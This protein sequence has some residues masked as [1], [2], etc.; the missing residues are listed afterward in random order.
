MSKD[1]TYSGIGIS[2]KGLISRQEILD[3]MEAIIALAGNLVGTPNGYAYFYDPEEKNLEVQVSLGCFEIV[4][5]QIGPGEGLAGRVWK[6]GQPLVVNNY[7][8]WPG[9]IRDN[10]FDRLCGAV[11]VPFKPKFGVGGVMG[12]GYAKEGKGFCQRDIAILNQFSLLASIALDNAYLHAKL[13]QELKE[14][15][16]LEDALTQ[17][18]RELEVKATDL[19]ELNT[20][21]GVLLRRRD[22]DKIELEKKVLF[23]I[24]QLVQPCI[25]ELEK[26]GLDGRQ[27]AYIKIL[28]SNLDD[29]VSRFLPIVSL[30]YLTPA[31]IRIANFIKY[32][33]TTKEVADL[34][35]LSVETVNSHRKHI[36]KKLGITNKKRY[37]GSFFLMSENM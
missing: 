13:E 7:I 35:C 14:R 21:L 29:I 12:L 16:R 17:R 37:L 8:K 28:R 6:T 1:P 4:G 36:R 34:L 11:G 32:G 18:E 2:L 5:L 30:D 25:T 23:N 20:A 27:A 10:R 19:E 31:E 9:R 22:E 3:L 15:K 33:K 26:S 24:K